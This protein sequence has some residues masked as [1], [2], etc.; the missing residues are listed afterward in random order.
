MRLE[1]ST[2]EIREPKTKSMAGG[3]IEGRMFIVGGFSPSGS[4]N[5]NFEYIPPK[6]LFV[7]EKN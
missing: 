5:S 3:V 2:L 7:H 6:T 4:G 1:D